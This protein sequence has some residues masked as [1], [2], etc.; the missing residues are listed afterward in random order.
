MMSDP[1]GAT[2]WRQL[3]A[4]ATISEGMFIGGE[5]RA[6]MDGSTRPVTSARDG[7]TLVNLAW[8][9]PAD[10]DAAVGPDHRLA[11]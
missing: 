8:A 11:G 4:D 9:Q 10:A 2:N 5:R 1:V 7:S 3:A 6:A